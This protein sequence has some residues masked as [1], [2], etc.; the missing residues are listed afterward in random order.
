MHDMLIDPLIRIEPFDELS[1]PE[2]LAALAGDNVR[3]VGWCTA[4]ESTADISTRFTHRL[5]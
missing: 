4:P 2:L 3:G 1:L 5:S